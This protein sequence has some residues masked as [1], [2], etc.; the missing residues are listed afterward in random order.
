MTEYL[1]LIG[2]EWAPSASARKFAS[3][4]PA[5]TDEVVGIFPA[6]NA[7]D[8][9]RAVEG[10]EAGRSEWKSASAERRA[11]VLDRTADV[12]LG[13]ASDLARD[14]T[15]EEGKTLA[16]AT[17]EVRR[18][19]A[20][21]RLYAGEALRLRGETFPADGNQLV[22]TIRQPVG[23]VVA[24]TPWNFPISIP[25][26][27][28]GPALAAGNGV[29]FKPSNHTALMGHRLVEALLEAG[30][31]PA[32]I[33]LVHG[34]GRE[35]GEALV[36]ADETR[37]I[38]FTG[39]Y[40]VGKRIYEIAGP[41]RRTQLEMG[42]KNPCIVLGDADLDRATQIIVRGAYGLAGQACTGTSRVLAV[43]DAY[44]GLVDRLAQAASA[45]KV[46]NG[47]DQGVQMGPLATEAQLEKVL[48]YVGIGARE[49]GERIVGGERLSGDSYDKGFFVSPAV[50]AGVPR[51]ARLSAEE[52]F[53]PVI[54][55]Q[56]AEDLDEAVALANDVE[57]GLAASIVTADL[58][59]A[60]E[61][62]SRVEAGVIKINSPT[63][64]V[65]LTA[66]FGGMKHSSNQIYKEQAGAGVM[67]LYTVAKTVYLSG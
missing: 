28:I 58:G 66:P 6:S 14:L 32:T 64:G 49:G 10:A 48:D 3:L 9:R 34:A 51:G 56:R 50:F 21:F 47:L 61:F 29:V 8:A 65:A 27:K 23:V 60:I 31:P 35:V 38:T 52:V 24:I 18:T 25:A 16:E 4:N 30:L 2:G 1:N 59:R 19:A 62:A 67:D 54:A 36:S 11:E 55:M 43:T 5:N 42:G 37:A 40:A 45:L 17:N 39:S 44:D 20:N 63:T 53:G 46:G 26:R 13:Q 41:D 57:Y 12:L 22:C 7:D 15:R 33:A